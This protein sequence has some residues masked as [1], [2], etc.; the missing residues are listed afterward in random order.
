MKINLHKLGLLITGIAVLTFLSIAGCASTPEESRNQVS[1][2]EIQA[3]QERARQQAEQEWEQAQQK[4]REEREARIVRGTINLRSD[5][6]GIV[7]INGEETQFK[8]IAGNEV[9]ITIENAVGN[10]Y[11]LAVKDSVGIVHQANS[12]ILIE[13]G[14][15]SAGQIFSYNAS[16][17]NTSPNVPGDFDVIQNANGITI[18]SYKGTRKSVVIPETLHGQRVTAIGEK[19]FQGKGIVSVVI[20]NSVVTIGDNAFGGY[21]GIRNI[22]KEVVIPDSVTSIGSDAFWSCGLTKVTIGRGVRFIDDDAFSNFFND[23]SATNNN[24]SELIVLAPL[25][26]YDRKVTGRSYNRVWKEY[27]DDYSQT[28]GLHPGA[29]GKL[30]SLTRVTLPANIHDGNLEA[31]PEGLVGYYKSQGKRAGT[32]VLNGPVWT[33]Q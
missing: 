28:L 24:I 27:M 14:L 4:A 33:R 13:R 26:T 8:A 17:I 2:D 10:E 6:A 20:P 1:D 32:Y 16:I 31:F 30:E 7:L 18:T 29:F 23:N 9:K 19:A 15:D 25:T 5:Y 3:R 12:K 22:I 11:T 21:G